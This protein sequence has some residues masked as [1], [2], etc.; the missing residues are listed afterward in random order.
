M[1][2]SIAMNFTLLNKLNWPSES[3]KGFKIGYLR[4]IF[5]PEQFYTHE[6]IKDA[7][8][9]AC[10]I[11][12]YWYHEDSE[13][14]IHLM[15]LLLELPK[16]RLTTKQKDLIISQ[17]IDNIEIFG[18]PAVIAE[19]LS[20]FIHWV[21]TIPKYQV[22][23]RHQNQLFLCFNKLCLG[24]AM[25]VDSQKLLNEIIQ[26]SQDEISIMS[27]AQNIPT[28][29]VHKTTEI[30]KRKLP[31][32]RF[33]S[34]NQ[35]ANTLTKTIPADMMT[36]KIQKADSV[37]SRREAMSR[38]RKVSSK[39]VIRRE[40]ADK[41]KSVYKKVIQQNDTLNDEEMNDYVTL[42]KRTLK[43][44]TKDQ[45]YEYKICPIVY[46]NFCKKNLPVSFIESNIP[47]DKH[48][49]N[50]RNKIIEEK[51]SL[52][53]CD[54]CKTNGVSVTLSV[55]RCRAYVSKY[56]KKYEKFKEV[57]F[58]GAFSLFNKLKKMQTQDITR[59][60]SMKKGMSS[61]SIRLGDN[62]EEIV[63]GNWNYRLL[64]FDI[65]EMFLFQEDIFWN[66]LYRF[67]EDK[68]DYVFMLPYEI[69][70]EQESDEESISDSS[71]MSTPRGDTEMKPIGFIPSKLSTFD[72]K[73]QK[74]SM[75]SQKP[76]DSDK[77]KSEKSRPLEQTES[78][79]AK[80]KLVKVT[81]RDSRKSF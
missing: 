33:N 31:F 80:S 27:S 21:K 41:D 14:R 62:I 23:W 25:S 29:E 65:K 30:E 78:K 36:L 7:I 22:D 54:Q 56:K 2:N 46:C 35:K 51:D 67:S 16:M 69:D 26:E 76:V 39:T 12:T 77:I 18:K 6:N 4:D 13:K 28:I 47:Q 64:Q 71:Q 57:K 70:M 34:C 19:N 61:M 50:L 9:L 3:L 11:G 48:K 37:V 59:V 8:W 63:I 1:L 24:L 58:L 10:W 60:T 66:L 73:H 44:N 79:F 5:N 49:E 81:S 32:E 53:H 15:Q 75:V 74:K 40:V 20:Y 55:S 43:Y 38:N 72:L 42:W 45:D 17:I 52:S 68:K